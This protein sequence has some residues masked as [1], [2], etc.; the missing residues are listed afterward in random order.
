MLRMDDFRSRYKDAMSG[1]SDKYGLV[2]FIVDVV[3]AGLDRYRDRSTAS[4]LPASLDLALAPVMARLRRVVCEHTRHLS[5]DRMREWDLLASLLMLRCIAPGCMKSTWERQ[6]L[7][8]ISR[9]FDE[10]P[11]DGSEGLVQRLYFNYQACFEDASSNNVHQ[12]R[13]KIL[14]SSVT[15]NLLHIR[16]EFG[17]TLLHHAAAAGA[18]DVIKFLVTEGLSPNGTDNQFKTPLHVAAAHLHY[19]TINVLLQCGASPSLKH[20]D[21][22]SQKP[23]D[24]FLQSCYLSA[25]HLRSSPSQLTNSLMLLSAQDSCSRYPW[26]QSLFARMIAVG[27]IALATYAV[28][29]AETSLVDL[30]KSTR[31]AAEL[32]RE[33]DEVKYQVRLALIHCIRRSRVR[34]AQLLL[35][36]LNN[37][38]DIFGPSPQ[39]MRFFFRCLE[40]VILS[41][42]VRFL[43]LLLETA[44]NVFSFMKNKFSS[45]PPSLVL[46]LAILKSDPLML[47]LLLDK[48]GESV[49]TWLCFPPQIFEGGVLEESDIGNVNSEL[50]VSLALGP[51]DTKSFINKL[52]M[53][54]P[55]A[56]SCIM[57][58]AV[59][60]D[61]MMSRCFVF[62]V[63]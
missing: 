25:W 36:R 2:R 13:R 53:F 8:L 5:S 59:A 12:L 32:N 7:D 33:I 18:L 4:R 20:A 28:S 15:V 56:F 46:H 30:L 58:D 55:I 23:L 60:L 11:F 9:D 19:E 29:T 40:L 24:C 51:F 47:R 1:S 17:W 10:S 26:S 31:Q 35:S 14:S 37:V 41:Q 44:G 6:L 57:N 3:A 52:E 62:F 54:N 21:E 49:C 45:H 38:L 42:S 48:I 39:D 16:D 50:R 34:I 27:D 22:N 63:I 61:L 43:V